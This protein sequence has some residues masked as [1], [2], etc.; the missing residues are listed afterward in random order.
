MANALPPPTGDAKN[1]P[2]EPVGWGKLFNWF[3]LL[4][5]SVT[6]LTFGADPSTYSAAVFSTIGQADTGGLSLL[7][8]SSVLPRLFTASTTYV[9]TAGCK[10]ILIE[11]VGAGGGG[12]GC[13][14]NGAGNS[15]VGISGGGGAYV[16][17]WLYPAP[18]NVSITIGGSG[19]GGAAGQNN[20]TAGGTTSFGSFISCPGGSGGGGGGST[21][22]VYSNAIGGMGSSA[23]TLSGVTLTLVAVAGMSSGLVVSAAGSAGAVG[24]GGASPLGSCGGNSGQQNGQNGQGYGAG[25]A[26]ACSFTT[27]GVGFAGGN[28]APGVV[29]I[30][31]VF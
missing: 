18:T 20:G 24:S 13:A 16:K 12:G 6:N 2:N 30:Y 31:E 4:W 10:G 5:K 23:P 14:A 1:P 25:G 26:G 22:S 9:P 19:T 27:S 7:F 21:A 15:S 3:Y 28:G 11:M 17:A 8:G 29:I